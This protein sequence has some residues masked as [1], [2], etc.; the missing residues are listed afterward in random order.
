MATAS[1]T[2]SPFIFP[3]LYEV[4]CLAADPLVDS[5]LLVS[6]LWNGRSSNYMLL[7]RLS[8][9]HLVDWTLGDTLLCLWQWPL[10]WAA[11]IDEIKWNMEA[12]IS[13]A[14]IGFYA[15]PG[16]SSESTRIKI[17]KT[18]SLNMRTSEE[19]W[20]LQALQVSTDNLRSPQQ[21][22]DVCK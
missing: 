21:T 10:R 4:I 17:V 19:D 9:R 13:A 8:V 15:P 14:A 5:A 3:R 12:V 1:F 18:E 16:I 20:I 6:P 2:E 11:Q 7:T 22:A